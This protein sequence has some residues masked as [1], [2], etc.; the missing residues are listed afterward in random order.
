MLWLHSPMCYPT[1]PRPLLSLEYPTIMTMH[2]MADAT[3]FLP[4]L[5]HR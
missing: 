4:S 1:L 3:M 5:Q 2:S